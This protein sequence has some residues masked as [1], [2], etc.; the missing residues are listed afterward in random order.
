MGLPLAGSNSPSFVLDEQ[1][2][3]T[4][5]AVRR[6]ILRASEQLPWQSNCLV[7]ALAA[8]MILKRRGLPSLLQL[9][10]CGGTARELF[11]HAWLRCGEIE[12]V[13]AENSAEFNPIAAFRP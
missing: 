4:V 1:R 2:S 6:A 7:H 10:V 9:G 13:G 5:L 8:K 11:A 12:V 3:A